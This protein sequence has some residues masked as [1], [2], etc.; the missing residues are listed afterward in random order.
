MLQRIQILYVLSLAL[1]LTLHIFNLGGEEGLKPLHIAAVLS[2]CLSFWMVPVKTYL[3]FLLL[4]FLLCVMLSSVFSPVEG[5]LKNGFI[6]VIVLYSCYGMAYVDLRML[7]KFLVVLIPVDAIVLMVYALQNPTYRYCGFYNDPNYLCTTLT[8]MLFMSLVAFSYFKSYV[9]RAVLVATIIL[10]LGIVMMTL[11]RTGVATCLLLLLC[12]SVWNM[13]ENMRKTIVIAVMGLFLLQHFAGEFIEGQWGLL[14]D[15]LFTRG[16]NLESAE[17]KRQELSLQN[18]RFIADHPGE[19]FFGLGPSGTSPNAVKQ[20]TG[21]SAYRV[22][23]QRDHNTWTACLAEQGLLAFIVM[24]LLFRLTGLNVFRVEDLRQKYLM[25]GLMGSLLIFSLS[26]WQM[27]YLPFWW[28]V[29][30]LNNEQLAE[31]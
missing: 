9:F 21:M 8:V 24:L 15:R 5:A 27:N 31:L 13:R 11:S 2:C 7:L 14:Y 22:D 16:D 26:I 18:L 20:I 10:L 4:G 29:F 3:H 28:A 30:L 6:I 1:S 17:G 19:V 12:Y 23:F 25:I